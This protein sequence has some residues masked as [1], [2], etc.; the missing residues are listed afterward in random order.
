LPSP[1]SRRA[2]ETNAGVSFTLRNRE[3]IR[4]DVVSAEGIKKSVPQLGFAQLARDEF[5]VCGHFGFVLQS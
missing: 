2:C 4:I 3:V 1:S 5:F